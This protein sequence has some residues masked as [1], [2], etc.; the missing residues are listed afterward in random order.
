VDTELTRGVATPLNLTDGDGTV[1]INRC[2]TETPTECEPLTP[3]TSKALHVDTD[4]LGA[5]VG[6]IADITTSHPS[7]TFVVTGDKPG[8]YSMTYHLEAVGSDVT[9]PGTTPASPET[10]TLDG[11]GD[12]DPA[13]VLAPASVPDGSY[14]VVGTIT[15]TG[16]DYAPYTNVAFTSAAFTIHRAGPLLT[17]ITAAPTTFYPLISG[18]STYKSTTKF[19]IVGDGVP[20][21][22]TLKLFK[23]STGAVVRTLTNVTLVDPTHLTVGW[24]GKLVDGTVVPGGLYKLKVY[25]ADGNLSSTVGSVTVSSKKLVTKT[26]THTYTPR[27]TL[28]DSYEGKCSTLRSPS[29]RGWYYS[30]GYYANTKCAS[31]TA[32]DS[33]VSTLHSVFLPKVHKYVDIRVTAYGGSAVAKPGSTA[34]IRY[35][36]TD[37][38]WENEKTMASTMGYHPGYTRSTTGMVFSDR[39]IGWGFYTGF[40]YQYDVKSFTVV[41]RYKTLG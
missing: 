41:L 13:P 24:T 9:V 39:S 36:N 32:E 40:G 28:A 6:T 37:G 29:R 12:T 22:T 26:W 35:L 1:T 5:S 18:D 31:Q 10:G 30:L 21:I 15:V 4:P 11:S 34:I 38:D 33:L 25:D 3:A 7:S 14:Q 16:S 23:N 2:S 17:S 20:E 19:T 27:G 8:N